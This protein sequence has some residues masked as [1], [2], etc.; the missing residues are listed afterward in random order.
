LT[1]FTIAPKCVL[2]YKNLASSFTHWLRG[3]NRQQI[4]EVSADV[5]IYIVSWV[6][7]L[8]ALKKKAEFSSETPLPPYKAT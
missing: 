7:I 5:S 1:Y 3:N 4:F 8:F 2:S 6:M